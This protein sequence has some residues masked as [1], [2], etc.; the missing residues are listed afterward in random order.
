MLINLSNHPY[1]I[2]NSNQKSAA[3]KYGACVD[4]PFPNV[5][6]FGDEAY[7]LHLAKSIVAE[8]EASYPLES[9]TVHI[10]GEMTLSYAIIKLLHQKPVKCIAST[11]K[12]IV[13]EKSDNTKEVIFDFIR[14]REYQNDFKL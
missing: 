7:I 10:M 12:R 3:E 4:F 6:P 5:D 8:I 13:K 2:W 1:S 14:F 9:I 11:T